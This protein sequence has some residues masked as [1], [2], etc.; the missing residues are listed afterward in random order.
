VTIG[1]SL[2]MCGL[3]FGIWMVGVWIAGLHTSVKG[4]QAVGGV[5]AVG[6]AVLLLVS[7]YVAIRAWQL[8]H[9]WRS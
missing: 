7:G 2:K 6:G 3:S 4:I 9:P 8:R 5:I 1:S